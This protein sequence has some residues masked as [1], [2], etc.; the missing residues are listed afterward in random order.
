LQLSLA[1]C[2]VIGAGQQAGSQPYIPELPLHFG[3]G[4]HD[5]GQAQL[6]VLIPNIIS[7]RKEA[8]QYLLFRTPLSWRVSEWV[9]VSG[10]L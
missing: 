6:G 7:G 4:L 10:R 1:I 2:K 8:V 9:T 5:H 3:E